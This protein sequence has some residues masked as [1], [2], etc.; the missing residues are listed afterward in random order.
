MLLLIIICVGIILSTRS[1]SEYDIQEISFPTGPVFSFEASAPIQSAGVVGN[2]RLSGSAETFK[3][4]NSKTILVQST[5]ILRVFRFV[6]D[7]FWIS[8][9]QHKKYESKICDQNIHRVRER[10]VTKSITVSKVITN[11]SSTESA[12]TRPLDC[13]HSLTHK[14][15]TSSL[16]LFKHIC[17]SSSL[18]ERRTE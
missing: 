9:T 1:V 2:P 18:N 15:M 11:V 14:Y 16:Y 7:L 10:Y 8:V 17:T 5:R 4:M 3:Q 12:Q 6:S 13:I